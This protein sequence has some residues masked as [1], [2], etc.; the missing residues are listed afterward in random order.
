VYLKGTSIQ[1]SNSKSV[2]CLVEEEVNHNRTDFSPLR[3][4][5]SLVFVRIEGPQF[6]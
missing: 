5:G 4:E 3:I 1:Y 6:F 2:E